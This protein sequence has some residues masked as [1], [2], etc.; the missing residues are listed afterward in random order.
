M[1]A[2]GLVGYIETP[3][4][5]R[6]FK[7]IWAQN[8]SDDFKRRLYKNWYRAKRKCFSKYNKKYS[9][10]E[11][12]IDHDIKLIKK[13]CHVIRLIV[14][15]QPKLINQ[16]G[17]KAHIY[18]V[19]INGGNNI[20]A[21]VDYGKNLFEKDIPVDTVYKTGD[22]ADIIGVTKGHG[23]T[24]VTK[25]YKVSKLPRKTHRGLRKVG[26]IG[27]WHPERVRFEVPRAGQLGYHH[28]TEINKRIYRVGIGKQANNAKTE[29]DETEKTINPMGGFPHYGLV[30]N[31][32]IMIK[33]CCVGPKKRVLVLRKPIVTPVKRINNEALNI[34]F[35]D[36]SSKMGHGRFQTSDERTKYYGPKKKKSAE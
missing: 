21:K 33:G 9:N 7:T 35:I 27:A 12:T 20:A 34:K 2:V 17:K 10:K 5:L 3:R 25:R 6:A 36:T 14:H 31:D 26:C 23:F 19:Q 4:G 29:F 16:R 13:Y 1:K 11:K 28:R 15:T 8:L 22:N 18:E 32:F 30:K 24:G